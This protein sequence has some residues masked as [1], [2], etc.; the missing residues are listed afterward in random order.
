MGLLCIYVWF[1]YM[2][3]ICI[4]VCLVYIYIYVIP[5]GI[6]IK[7]KPSISLWRDESISVWKNVIFTAEQES[8]KLLHH[9]SPEN[10]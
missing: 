8:L 5:T 10:A 7:K 3:Y 4:Y 1:R 2:V 9:Q 6:C